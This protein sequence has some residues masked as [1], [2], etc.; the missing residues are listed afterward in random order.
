V[1]WDTTKKTT[2][3]TAVSGVGYFCDTTSAAFTATLPAT[4]SAGDIIGIRDYAQTFANNNLTIGSEYTSGSSG[5][6]NINIG[7]VNIYD[8]PL[9]ASEVLQNFNATKTRFGL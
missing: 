7:N 1:N 9:S 3:F 6:S 4:P 2:G 8:R 5:F